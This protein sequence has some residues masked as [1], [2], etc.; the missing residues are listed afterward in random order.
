MIVMSHDRQSRVPAASCLAWSQDRHNIL[1][2]ALD[3]DDPELQAIREAR[4]KQLQQLQ[5]MSVPLP[6]F[7][8]VP[9]MPPQAAYNAPPEP[10]RK[11]ALLIDL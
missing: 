5:Q 3:M 9:H 6:S 1:R 2:S 10:E 11:E 7:P 4:L 8:Q